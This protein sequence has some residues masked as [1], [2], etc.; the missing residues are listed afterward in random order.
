MLYISIITLPASK[1]AV[2]QFRRGR[3]LCSGIASVL[4]NSSHRAYLSNLINWVGTIINQK[5][6]LFHGK[7]IYKSPTRHDY[8]GS[9]PEG[10][11]SIF[12]PQP[13]TQSNKSGHRAISNPPAPN[14]LC[15]INFPKTAQ[16]SSSGQPQP[17]ATASLGS[18]LSQ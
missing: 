7:A 12:I 5:M 9:H 6:K 10:L 16:Q 4:F 13:H 1:K 15:G 11:H 17:A 3:Y 14:R 18:F 8:H 2:F